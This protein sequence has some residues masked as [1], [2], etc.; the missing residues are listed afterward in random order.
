[1]FNLIPEITKLHPQMT[2]WR[3]HLHAHPEIALQEVQTAQFIADKLEGWGIRVVRGIGAATSVVSIIEGAQGAGRS[4]ALRADIDALPMVETAPLPYMSQNH[5]AYHACGHD[6]HTSM[7]LGAAHYLQHNRNFKG[8]VV[9]IFQPAEEAIGGAK[10]MVDDGL[11]EKFPC[12]AAFAMHN[13]PELE[14]G[15]IATFAGPVMAAI[16]DLKITI[17]GKGGHAAYPHQCIDPVLVGAHFITAV[18]S[19]ISRNK[20]PLASAVISLPMFHGGEATN[21]IPETVELQGTMRTFDTAVQKQLSNRL[22]ELA[23]GLSVAFNAQINVQ[24]DKFYP[25]TVNNAAM[26]SFVA[27]V[28]DTVLKDKKTMRDVPPAMGAEDFAYIAQAVPSCYFWVGQGDQTGFCHAATYNFND[29]IL[30]LGA[31]LFSK[32][33]LEFLNT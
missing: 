13:W 28:I 23:K 7:L 31:T 33:A 9:L 26:A 21:V 11:F 15:E 19:L 16:D 3:Q 22:Y 29:E 30:P 20:N 5:G 32:L 18:Q 2:A 4:V 10:L 17:T 14:V 1:M 8:R 12:D 25:A 6:G 27:D 24:I